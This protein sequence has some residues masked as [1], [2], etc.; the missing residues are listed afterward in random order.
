MKSLLKWSWLLAVVVALAMTTAGVALAQASPPAPEAHVKGT[1]TAMGTGAQP[2][3]VTITPKEGA[4]V[5]IKVVATT[6]IT[7]AGLGK[8][9]LD[10][11]A[12][13][14]RAGAT[15]HQDTL[16]AIRI[17][18]THPA[19]R[20]HGFTGTIK[21]KISSTGFVLTTKQQG[22]VTISVNGETKYK[23]PALEDA[24]LD[25]FKVGDSVAVLAVDIKGNWVALHMH[26]IPGK[27]SHVHRVGT[28]EAYQAASAGTAGSITLKDKDRVTYTFAVTSE[29]EIKFKRGATEVK[30]GEKAIVVARRDPST[31]KFT[32]KEI[33]VFGPKRGPDRP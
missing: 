29:T 21:Q 17:A 28:I 26:L 24:G 8:A 31:D 14:D 2:P 9:N 12:V 15:Y 7:K 30:L 5:T 33:M 22:E 13:G 23:V 10:E 20:H 6:R 3:T 19:A 27:P 4:A 18:A 25:N 32:A 16:E 11:L 1:I